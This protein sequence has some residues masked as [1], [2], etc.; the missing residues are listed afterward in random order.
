MPQANANGI[1]IEYDTFGDPS[2][3]PLILI[4][5]LGTQLTRWNTEFCDMLVAVG[6]YVVRFDNRDVGLTSKI[7]T[8]PIPNFGKAM[9]AL[10]KGEKVDVPYTLDDMA[11]DTVG[12]MDELGI[13][14]AH[15]C[16]VSMGGMIAQTVAIRHPDRVR[17]MISIMSKMGTPDDLPATPEAAKVLM[18]PAPTERDACIEN[19]VKNQQ[20]IGS[21][22][23]PF[24]EK[25]VRQVAAQDYD[26]A[27]YPQGIGRQMLAITAHG[28][29]KA[30][31]E[32]TVIPTLVMHGTEDPLIPME[33]GKMTAAAIKG[34]ELLLIKGMGHDLPSG[35]WPQIV[36]AISQH[37]RKVDKNES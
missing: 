32:K 4:S 17:S 14:K 29:R 8:V 22:G 11:D 9:I 21:P 15:I 23:F 37:T 2:A 12:L 31:L 26:R 34:A 6:H 5:G 13:D 3:S 1:Q 28:N 7:E 25:E 19:T 20:V 18:T 16:G 10:G 24:N 33:N 35:A 36:K 27:F 30:A